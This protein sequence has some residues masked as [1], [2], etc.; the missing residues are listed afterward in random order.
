MSE[1]LK[2]H[3]HGATLVLTLSNPGLGN[4]LGPGIYQR[5]GEMLEQAAVAED[6]RSVVVTGEGGRFSAGGNLHR[7]QSNRQNSKEVQAQGIELLHRWI[8]SIRA[9]PKPVIAAVEGAAAGAGFSL[10]LACDLIVAAEDSVFLM[11]YSSIGLSP[12]G[13]ATWALSQRVP[14]QLAAE[15]LMLGERI[16][17]RRLHALG[18]VNQLA[19]PGSALDAALD[20]AERINERATNAMRSCKSLLNDAP[21]HSLQ[22]QLDL[23]KNHFVNNLHHPNT[24]IGIQA[25]LDKKKPVFQPGS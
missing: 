7:L 4:A 25:F 1:E 18:V 17:A 23:E 21:R 5:G 9:F 22:Q 10:A 6:I 3:Q 19:A 2:V 8:M 11:A 16:S 12:D 13:G 20:L 14:Q 15:W 24:G